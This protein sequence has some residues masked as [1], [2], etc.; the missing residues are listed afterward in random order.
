MQ[1]DV[2]VLH[3]LPQPFD[4]HIHVKIGYQAGV[5]DDDV[6]AVIAET[7]GEETALGDTEKAALRMARQLTLDAQID[8]ATYATLAQA[9]PDD[10]LIDLV[11]TVCHYNSA[12]RFLNG[13]EVELEAEY[14]AVVSKFPM[15]ALP[16]KTSEPV[17]NQS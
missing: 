15:P 10:A 4:E 16:R 5:T 1:V 11:M 17:R 6:R 13:F 9:F 3:A 12:A 8:D 7:A 14:E 2:L